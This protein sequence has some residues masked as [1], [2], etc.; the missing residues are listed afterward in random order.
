MAD[1]IYIQDLRAQCIIGV[2]EDE[3]TQK[4][5]V[6]FNV[7]LSCDLSEAAASDDLGKTVDYRALK[8][9]IVEMTEQSDFF[10]IER[11]AGTVAEMCFD[12]PRVSA[13]TVRVDKPGALTFARS[14]AVEVHRTR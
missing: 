6:I 9:R 5:E 13:A 10:L 2:N 7:T 14:V 8:D 3:R 1:R 4:Q 12:D 11:L